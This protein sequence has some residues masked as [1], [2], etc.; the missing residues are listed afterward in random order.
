MVN[1]NLG[2]T[3][4]FYQTGPWEFHGALAIQNLLGGSFNTLSMPLFGISKNPITQPTSI[5]LG[6][7]V[8]R[9]EW[10]YFHDSTAAIETTDILNNAAGSFF[11]LIHF[12]AETHWRSLALR[13]GLNQGY[14]TAGL[15]LDVHSFTFNLAT[16]GEDF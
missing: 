4:Q 10:G 9:K 16:Y 3:Y 11:R 15:G 12:G 7:S 14:I 1:A 13:A 6:V 8:V 2:G 5:G